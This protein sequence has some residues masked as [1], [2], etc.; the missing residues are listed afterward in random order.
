MAASASTTVGG[1][2]SRVPLLVTAIAVSLGLL[3]GGATE[4]SFATASWQWYKA[5]FH[6][7]SVVSADAFPDLGVISTSAKANG[8]NAIFLTDHNLG[9][10][11]PISGMTAN[12][13]FFEDSY[14]RWTSATTGSLSAGTNQLVTSPVASGTSSLHL[15]STS[16][17]AGETFVWTKRG[18]NF[19]TGTSDAI[20]RFKVRPN[21]LDAGSGL[22]VSAAVGGDPTVKSPAN[23]PVGYTTTAGAVSPGKSTVLVFYFGAPPPA[24]FYGS[25]HVLAYDLDSGYC[26]RPFELGAWISCTVDVRSKLADLPPADQPLAYNGLSDLKLSSVAQGGTA[27]AY[28]DSY[29]IDATSSSEDEFVERNDVIGSYDTPSF[30]IFPSVEMGVNKHANR[31]NFGITT[32]A[33]FTSYRD[34]IDGILPTQ[35]TGY[36]AQLNHPGVDGGVT[37]AA[38]ISTDAEGAD[39]LEVRQQNMINDWDAILRNGKPV[40]GTWGGDNHIGRWTLGSQV[41]FVSAPALTFDELMHSIFEGRAYMGQ[42]SFVGGFSLNLDPA[43]QEPY[44]ARYP[45]YVSPARTTIPAHVAIGGGLRSGDVVRWL[46]NDGSASTTS[47]LASDPTSSAAYDATNPVPLGGVA[48]YVRAEVRSS[49]GTLRGLSEPILFADVAGLPA[50]ISYH[51]HRITTPS[52]H[53]YTRIASEGVTSTAWDATADALSL[54]LTDPAGSLV[55]LRGTSAAS[56]TGVEVDG[57]AVSEAGSLADFDSATGSTW[58]YDAATNGLYLKVLQAGATAAVRVAFAPASP[59]PPQTIT[60]IPAADAF[61]TSVSP[62]TNFGHSLAFYVDGNGIRKSYVRFDLSSL[63][64]AVSSATL[65]IWGNS[66]QSIGYDVFGVDDT[67]WDESTIDWEN[68]PTSWDTSPTGSSGP[69]G[70]GTWTSVDVTRLVQAAAGGALNL[71]LSTTSTTN[72]SLGSR[73]SIHKPQLVIATG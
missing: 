62:T 55:E 16:G 35:Q 8:F 34:G 65:R 50:H 24:S 43:S 6:V 29:S 25:A 70:A 39:L 71:G 57:A 44:P 60:L 68:Q 32:P 23:N 10:N 27:D 20:L 45:V 28:F 42:S 11:F 26:D 63:A 51:V 47:V 37:D 72:L 64:G 38:A 53:D 13:M 69:V 54:G 4:R 67:S 2:V 40:V 56:P 31:F 1:H 7:H 3:L 73:E 15:A 52:G 61:V 49:S 66:T 14:R 17:T 58:F 41:T 12:H 30:R 18:P 19:R 22:Y 5:D 9:S 21:Q 48:S 33:Q 36:P 46:A 59:P